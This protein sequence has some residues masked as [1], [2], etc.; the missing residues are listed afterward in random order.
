M[1]EQL[2]GLDHVVVV[3]RDLERAARDWRDLGFTLSP[4]GTH[5]AHM[6]TGNYTIMFGEDYIELLGVLAPT[7][8]NAPTRDWLARREGI[9]RIA[10]TT[11]DA[12]AGVAELQARGVAATG[13]LDFGR[14][15]ELPDGGSTQAR[16]RTFNWPVDEQPGGVRLFAC[17]HLTRDA[18]W[19]PQLQRHA[20]R[21][22]RIGR[23]ELLSRD[24]SAAA[25]RMARLIDATP[26]QQDDGAWRV[27][28]GGARADLV[29]LDR[30]ALAGRYPGAAV[31][32]LAD[33][34]AA[35][36]VL[37]VADLARAREALAAVPA[38]DSPSGG[39]VV[40]AGRASGLMLVFEQ[41]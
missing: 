18:V 25:A 1:M 38:L 36:L 11:T 15:V 3:V 31:D 7:P 10:F 32:P 34:G 22:T 26:T 20:N 4:R 13:P 24:P 33:E 37:R 12:A 30:A 39:I 27:P 29:F 17:Q 19:V 9:E 35:A 14:P 16:F 5:S 8:H 23:I 2:V 28:T 6:G 41:A 21:A 40:P